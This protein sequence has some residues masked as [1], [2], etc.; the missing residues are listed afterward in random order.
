MALRPGMLVQAR[1]GPNATALVELT[2]RS[3]CRGENCGAP[4]W[5]ARTPQGRAMPLDVPE[6]EDAGPLEPHHATCP[7]A[8]SFRR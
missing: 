3:T 4:I 8:G 2:N 6:D 7:D 5:W 1:L